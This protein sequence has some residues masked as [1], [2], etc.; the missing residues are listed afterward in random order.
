VVKLL[1][2]KGADFEVID[3]VYG[4]TPLSWAATKG[5]K[6]VVKLLLEKEVGLEA[7][8]KYG[9]TPLSLAVSRGYKAV[10]KPQW[11]SSSTIAS[12]LF[13]PAHDSGGWPVLSLDSK[14]APLSSSSFT[15]ASCPFSAAKNSSVWPL[16]SLDSRS[17]LATYCLIYP[18][19][20]RQRCLAVMV[21]ATFSVKIKK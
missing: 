8:D 4:Q 1:L 14:S 13:L 5:H 16:S 18:C 12:S 3:T 10:V 2:D 15:T 21:P 19:S 11:S 20:Q 7:R 9:Q 17:A 6:A